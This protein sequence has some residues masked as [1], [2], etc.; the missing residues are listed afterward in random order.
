VKEK[1]DK[2]SELELQL[3]Q[4][5]RNKSLVV[6][7]KNAAAAKQKEAE[8]LVRSSKVRTTRRRRI[9]IAMVMFS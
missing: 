4:A 3:L 7:A 9:S 6:S 8:A 2:I 5:S 1:A